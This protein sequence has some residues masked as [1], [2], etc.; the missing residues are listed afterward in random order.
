MGCDQLQQVF[1]GL[2]VW[3]LLELSGEVEVVPA[4]DA[5][6]DQSIAGLGDFLLFLFGLGEPTRISDGD[7]AGEAVGQLY[8]VE[9]FFNGLS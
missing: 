3:C 5:V 8:L 9:L 7:C 6:F 1:S 2:D 4:D